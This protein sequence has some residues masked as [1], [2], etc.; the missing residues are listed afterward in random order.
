MA[1]IEGGIHNYSDTKSYVWPR[2]PEV[3]K[4]LSWFQD[5]KLGLMMHWGPYSQLGVVESWALSDEDASWAREGIDWQVSGEEFKKQYFDLNKTF[6]PIRFEPQK[7]ATLAKNGGMRY[8]L[9][10]TKHHDGFCMWD[11]QYTEY[12]ITGSDCPFHS[13][14]YQDICA[15]LFEEFRK[16]K[17]GIIAYFSKADWHAD[18]YWLK[19]CPQGKYRTRSA[20]YNPATN[21]EKWQEFVTYTHNQIRELGNNYGA[22]DGMWFDAGWVCAKYG[23]DIRFG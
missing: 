1:E 23:E 3:I 20:S 17:L 15:H 10:T 14:M 2:D 9:F 6:N 12:K 8:V 4:K 13:H 21:P 11:S 16:K 22:I 5:Q 18:S 7:W 19:D